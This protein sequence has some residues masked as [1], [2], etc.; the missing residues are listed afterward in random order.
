M[1]PVLG[2]P[3]VYG[4]EAVAVVEHIVAG[5]LQVQA[6]SGRTRVGDQDTEACRV[7]EASHGFRPVLLPGGTIVGG[8][9][10]SG[11]VEHPRY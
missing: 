3:T 5:A 1:H 4:I 8:I 11:V 2:L 10:R 7:Q 6:S 9:G